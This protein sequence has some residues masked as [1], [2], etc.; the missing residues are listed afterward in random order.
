MKF[1]PENLLTLPVGNYELKRSPYI[2]S[3]S[4]FER[5]E[6]NVSLHEGNR[7]YYM[8]RFPERFTIT[9]EKNEGNLYFD[10]CVVVA[11]SVFRISE[12]SLIDLHKYEINLETIK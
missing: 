4:Y 2:S 6:L 3:P 7:L 5:T 1:T 12:N 11:S 8:G 10:A 9:I